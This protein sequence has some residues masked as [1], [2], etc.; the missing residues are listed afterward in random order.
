MQTTP[1][2]IGF[3]R[4]ARRYDVSPLAVYRWAREGRGNPR[5]KL[6]AIKCGGRWRTRWRWVREF[7]ASLQ[8]ESPAPLQSRSERRSEH[9]AVMAD[10]RQLG[11]K[12]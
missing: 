10:L 2:Y 7:F 3:G 4:V 8:P 12:C 1:K 6:R 11:V 5:I 9:A